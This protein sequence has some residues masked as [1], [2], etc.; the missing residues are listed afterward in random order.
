MSSTTLSIVIPAYNESESI[1]ILL[2]EIE[3]LRPLFAGLEE[4][5]VVDD[6]SDDGTDVVL[7]ELGERF[8]WLSVIRFDRNRGQTAALAAGF[9]AARGDIVATLDADLQNDPSDIPRLIEVLAES[10][11]DM[12]AG[13]R[14]RRMDSMWKRIQSRIGNGVRNWITTDRVSDTGCTLRVSKRLILVGLLDFEGAHRFIPTLVRVRGGVVVEE[15][16]S[17]RPRR[18]GESKYG[19]WNRVLVGLIRCFHVRRLRRRAL[20]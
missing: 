18:F 1:P 8:G 10:G 11:A 3:G 7:A 19:A 17:H 2:E 9:E 13:I 14:H 16:V 4:V 5:I 15:P 12:V 20:R 6:G